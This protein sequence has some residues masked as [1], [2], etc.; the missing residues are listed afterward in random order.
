MMALRTAATG[1]AAQDLNDAPA[2][3]LPGRRPVSNFNIDNHA[4]KVVPFRGSSGLVAKHAV[5]GMFS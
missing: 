1:M 4:F 3:I 5:D 2:R